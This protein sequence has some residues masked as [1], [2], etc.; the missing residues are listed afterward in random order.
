MKNKL[1]MK[2][3]KRVKMYERNGIYYVYSE[4]LA[5]W[6]GKDKK[7]AL[8]YYRTSVIYLAKK[9]FGFKPKKRIL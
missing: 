3:R 2:C 6:F 4:F 8:M 7:Y 1:L 5:D 9:Y